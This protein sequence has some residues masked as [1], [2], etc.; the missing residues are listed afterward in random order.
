M[1]SKRTLAN[2]EYIAKYKARNQEIVNNYKMN[3]GCEDTRCQWEG[4]FT[5]QMLHLD[6]IDRSTKIS[7]LSTA[8]NRGWS[9]KKLMEEVAKCRVLCANCHHRKT[10]E[11]KEHYEQTIQRH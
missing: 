11:D 4:E 6:H 2:R 8:C 5:P 1:A 10:Y 9:V 3:T 7:D